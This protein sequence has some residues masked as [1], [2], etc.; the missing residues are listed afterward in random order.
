MSTLEQY[1][2]G[3]AEL[4]W[5]EMG[6]W[7][8]AFKWIFIFAH[9]GKYVLSSIL[10]VHVVIGLIPPAMLVGIYWYRAG[11][12]KMF[13]VQLSATVFSIIVSCTATALHVSLGG[14]RDSAY[15][16]MWTLCAVMIMILYEADRR[17][18][19]LTIAVFTV[20]YMCDMAV[21]FGVSQALPTYIEYPMHAVHSWLRAVIPLEPIPSLQ[22]P[23]IY[24]AMCMNNF[25]TPM[26]MLVWALVKVTRSRQQW[27]VKSDELIYNLVPPHIADQMR[28][29]V[30]RKELTDTH[31]DVT[32]F[33]SDIV[34]YTEICDRM[35][36]PAHA[37]Q[38]LD[39]MYVGFDFLAERTGVYKVETIG[40]AYF[41]VASLNG[42]GRS[43][44]ES[45]Y[46]MAIFALAVLEFM[47]G[48]FGQVRRVTTTQTQS[49]QP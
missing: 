6:I 18:V 38:L 46:R 23:V 29:G 36:S 27:Q 43:T 34:G 11:R 24:G 22:H 44:E 16:C 42:S 8:V 28:R 26:G 9:V 31:T 7:F 33:F 15:L 14:W 41:A 45:C 37:I 4:L 2:G 25:F 39:Q 10:R 13:D 3:I 21:E 1:Q 49:P 35:E 17:I 47:R 48:P 30:H 12:V 20:A 5:I 32:R 40:D 19:Q